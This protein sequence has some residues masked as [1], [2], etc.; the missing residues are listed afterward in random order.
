MKV[1]VSEAKVEETPKMLEKIL[2]ENTICFVFLKLHISKC[3][4]FYFKL[5]HFSS[6]CLFI[7]DIDHF[8]EI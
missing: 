6:Q 8:T 4:W 5:C 7:K 2:K 1:K 3:F